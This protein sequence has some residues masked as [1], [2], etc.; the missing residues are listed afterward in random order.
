MTCYLALTEAKQ[1]AIGFK[2]HDSDVGKSFFI[3]FLN[4]AF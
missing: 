2:R 1:P 4:V 3:Y